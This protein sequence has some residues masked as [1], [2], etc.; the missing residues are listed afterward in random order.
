VTESRDLTQAPATITRGVTATAATT[1]TLFDV[2]EMELNFGPQHPST[3]GVL[4][5]K[6]RID[7]ERIVDCYPIVGYLHRGT[8][9]LFELHPF[10]QN[11]PHT[12]RMDYV[13]A[14][15]NNLAYVGAVEKLVG[16]QVPPRARYIRVLLAE[17]QRISSHLLWLATHAIDIG[18][19][20]PFFYCFREREQVL[21]LFEEY[22]GARLT[23]NCMRPGG[24][25]YDFT[26]GW[27]DR[28][29][30]F[31]ETFP[32]KVDEYEGLLTNNRIWK[33]RTVGVGILP[34]EMALDYGISGPML[35]GSGI[36][37]DLRKARPYE[38]YADVQFDVP[39]RHGCD[40]YDRYLV[41]I[42]EMRQS[43]RIILQCLDKLPEGP[44]MAKRPR[45]LKGPKEGE[46]YH[47]IEGPKGEIGF[48]IVSDGTPNPYR[49]HVRAP[50]FI[51]LQS[52]P[53]L[54]RGALL[55]DLV[56]IIGTTDI[57]L[58]EVDR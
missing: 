57:V 51:N 14:A 30:E 26:V 41:R 6:L 12:D 55:A 4:R 35:R 33:T 43:A 9:K 20:T 53:D 49:C 5:L 11:V 13:A 31:T 16:L 29:R 50:S 15:T 54:C 40:T 46:V 7:G 22:C 37:W 28:C 52:L 27:T 58:G 23:L 56:A 2:E 8:E 1:E 17:L 39:V 47:S 48:Y 32:S 38:A 10:F 44:V 19:M 25:P 36:G 34:P 42:E 24:Q 45:V 3:H 21:D 18:A